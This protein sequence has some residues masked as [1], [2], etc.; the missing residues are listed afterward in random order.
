[1]QANKLFPV[2][3]TGSE[4]RAG[5]FAI[6]EREAKN[7]SFAVLGYE[8]LPADIQF[9]IVDQVVLETNEVNADGVR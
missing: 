8:E 6:L 4:V 3:V 1:M 9:D 5:I 7:R 2:F